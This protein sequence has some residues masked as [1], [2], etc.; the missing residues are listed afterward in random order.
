[1]F[2]KYLTVL[3]SSSDNELFNLTTKDPPTQGTMAWL[4]SQ[5]TSF[6]LSHYY[7]QSSINFTDI[8]TQEFKYPILNEGN[9]TEATSL[10]SVLV[11]NPRATIESRE[12]R[13]DGSGRIE[14]ME[15]KPLVRQGNLHTSQTKLLLSNVSL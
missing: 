15:S 7:D 9:I 11:C 10:V 6:K 2:L 4:V 3:D 8:P 13:A 14:V 12:V 1:M 5:C